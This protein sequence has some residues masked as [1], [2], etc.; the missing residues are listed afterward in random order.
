MGRVDWNMKLLAAPAKFPGLFP[1]GKSGLKFA[2]KGSVLRPQGVS[3]RMGR[4]DWNDVC[5]CIKFCGRSLF[6]YGKS[7]LKSR[8]ELIYHSRFWSLPVWEE[9]IEIICDCVNPLPYGVSSRMGRVDWNLLIIYICCTL[10]CLFPYGKSGLK[11]RKQRGT[12]CGWWVS[13]RMGRVDWNTQ[14]LTNIW[15]EVVSSR[16]GRVDWNC[17]K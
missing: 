10:F 13:S 9:W 14:I 6:P 8:S 3:S 5:D 17:Y 15:K 2:C 4:V 12:L 16:M 1:Y 11:W 7:G